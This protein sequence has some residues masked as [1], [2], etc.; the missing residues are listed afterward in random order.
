MP[1]WCDAMASRNNLR[2]MI[3]LAHADTFASCGEHAGCLAAVSLYAARGV[4]TLTQRREKPS[5]VLRRCW[6]NSN[7]TRLDGPLSG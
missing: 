6:A 5:P 3:P 1:P 7:A 2:T 4:P